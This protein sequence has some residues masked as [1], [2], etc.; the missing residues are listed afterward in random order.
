MAK[1]Y[2]RFAS[3]CPE[4]FL[5]LPWELDA[6]SASGNNISMT[7]R[8]TRGLLLICSLILVF[9]PGWCCVI[10]CAKAQPSAAPPIKA[11]CCCAEKTKPSESP[12]LPT[13]PLK[14]CCCI[15]ALTKPPAG[16]ETPQPD[17]I[18]SLAPS[19]LESG[20]SRIA[21]T[22]Y[23]TPSLPSSRTLH[24]LVCVWLC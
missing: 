1:S 14:N 12:S 18:A 8:W 2:A 7:I 22:L 11:A 10:A 5:S 21:D 20:P 16:G 19:R 6:R 23:D 9:P 13:P 4:R 15:T 3:V 17:A 24:L